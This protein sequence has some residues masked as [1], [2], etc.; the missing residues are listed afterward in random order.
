MPVSAASPTVRKL[1]FGVA[2]VAL[3]ALGWHLLHR[4]RSISFGQRC[5]GVLRASAPIRNEMPRGREDRWSF[6]GLAGQTATLGAESFEFDIYLSLLDNS[7]R[8]IAWSDGSSALLGPSIRAI[9]PRTGVYTAII[10]GSNHEQLGTYWVSLHEGQEE[11]DSSQ[12]GVEAYYQRGVEWA[13]RSSSFRALTRLKLGMGRYLRERRQLAEAER[14]DAEG[15]ADA[16]QHNFTYGQCAARLELGRLLARRMRCAE[17]VEQF[18]SALELSEKL[19]E[20]PEAGGAVLIEL[21]NLY[22]QTKRPVLAKICFETASTLV[23]QSGLPAAL[24]DEYTSLSAVLSEEDSQKAIEYACKAYAL[25]NGLEPTLKLKATS[26]LA[27]AR[28]L[29][30]AGE[31]AEGMKLADESREMASRL[32][33]VDEEIALTTLISM[34]HYKWNKIDEMVRSAHQ[35]LALTDIDDEDPG[36]RRVAL[37]LEADGEMARGNYSVAYE[38]CMKALV[39]LENDWARETEEE[40][41]QYLLSQSKAICTQIIKNLY[42]LN[43]GR[44]SPACARQAFDFAE[45]SQSRSLLQEIARH[46]DDTVAETDPE[47]YDEDRQLLGKLSAL[48]AQMIHLR[49][50]GPLD[51]DTFL[52]MEGERESLVAERRRVQARMQG[53]NGTP[54]RLITPISA[55]QAQGQYLAAH[56]NTVILYY[57][58]GVQESF[59]IALSRKDAQLFKLA[60]R[61]SIARAVTAWR[62]RI[63]REVKVAKPNAAA[64]RHDALA[65]HELYNTLVR[66]AANLIRGRDIL[67]IPSDILNGLAFEALVVNDPNE[68]GGEAPLKYFLEQHRVAYAPSVSTMALIE[69]RAAD[70]SRSNRMLLIGDSVDSSTES[71]T[72][73]ADQRSES[74]AVTTRGDE[75]DDQAGTDPDWLPGARREVVEIARLA[76]EQHIDPVVWLGL[77]TNK[78]KLMTD[79][80]GDFRFIHLAM[81]SLADYQNGYFSALTS[82]AGRMGNRDGILTSYE[83]AG[84]RLQAE[85]VVL[86]GCETGAGRGAGAEG[87]IGLT[88]TFLIAG[89]HRVCASLWNVEDSSAQKLMSRFYASLLTEGLSPTEA[90]RH[91]K[92]TMLRQGEAPSRWAAFVLVG[93]PS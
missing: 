62:S 78:Q 63:Q 61:A 13:K 64:L 51:R 16:S 89:A 37:Q 65:A 60:N 55:V 11:V 93:S 21:G 3:A 8:Q 76:A 74:G 22:R 2:A 59:L 91:A 70:P 33:F 39:T 30:E 28:L 56:P 44:S 82:A 4:S 38:D 42:A 75:A 7:G 84:L 40:E 77:D 14:Y 47:V 32:G 34:A 49:A 79:G 71:I 19:R 67:T 15:L 66:P 12:A 6:N 85:M 90:L 5:E 81:H 27:G 31:E 80:L 57:Q 50:Q 53:G 25:S 10:C 35:A 58:L 26:A 46:Q 83:I 9:L 52:Q 73:G 1:L 29:L 41:R 36:P 20:V 87:I 69:K 43:A 18:H 72:A 86:S 68:Q 48:G 54:S 17:A 88:R 92:L 23:E 45:R 24:V